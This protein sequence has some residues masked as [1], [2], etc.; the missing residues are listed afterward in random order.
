[1]AVVLYYP[2]KMSVCNNEAVTFK[3]TSNPNLLE[4]N[5]VIF[6]LTRN[7]WQQEQI[8][9]WDMENYEPVGMEAQKIFTAVSRIYQQ[10]D[11]NQTWLLSLS[12]IRH[13]VN[14]HINMILSQSLPLPVST[15]HTM[16]SFFSFLLSFFYHHLLM[17][18]SMM[19]AWKNCSDP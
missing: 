5:T 16:Q 4:P 11:R 18:I 10:R 2:S 1:M 17:I 7:T 13:L 8:I 19:S 9:T 3:E 15:Q 12:C 14:L 6:L